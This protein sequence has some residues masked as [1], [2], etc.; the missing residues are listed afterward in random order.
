MAS[1]KAASRCASSVVVPTLPI[2][3]AS[4]NAFAKFKPSGRGALRSGGMF[5]NSPLCSSRSCCSPAMSATCNPS[6]NSRAASQKS[7]RSW[8]PRTS[9]AS[10]ALDVEAMREAQ[11][12]SWRQACNSWEFRAHAF[13]RSVS[14]SASDSRGCSPEPVWRPDDGSERK[15]K[16]GGSGKLMICTRCTQCVTRMSSWILGQSS[17]GAERS[18]PHRRL[19]TFCSKAPGSARASKWCCSNTSD[20]QTGNSCFM[21]SAQDDIA[22]PANALHAA[23][24]NR[25]ARLVRYSA[26]SLAW[27]LPSKS[28]KKPMVTVSPLPSTVKRSDL[29]TSPPPAISAL[30]AWHSIG[31]APS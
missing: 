29:S 16:V 7:G 27:H 18:T 3:R 22:P 13:S 10:S 14:R 8:I 28:R 11:P 5:A 1:R 23:S 25:L 12:T 31:I 15:A 21:C 30:P 19:K 20:S 4:A 17:T 6:S 24:T 9:R 26:T 2:P